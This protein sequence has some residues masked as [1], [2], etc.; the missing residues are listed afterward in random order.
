M[1]IR[2]SRTIFNS[3]L[4]LRE[5]QTNITL[6]LT[7]NFVLAN[8]NRQASLFV[9]INRNIKSVIPVCHMIISISSGDNKGIVTTSRVGM[10]FLKAICTHQGWP[11]FSR[12]TLSNSFVPIH[13]VVHSVRIF[14]LLHFCFLPYQWKRRSTTDSLV[15]IRRSTP[16][17]VT[18]IIQG[19]TLRSE[20]A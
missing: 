6:A 4:D 8:A 5:S 13:F 15:R 10:Q 9:C 2:Y 14:D 7:T 18:T 1:H 16:H 19:D 12:F 11:H 17:L 20:E 3:V